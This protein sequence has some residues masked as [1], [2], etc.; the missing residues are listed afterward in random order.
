MSAVFRVDRLHT[1]ITTGDKPALML[2]GQA[3]LAFKQK[4]LYGSY[5]FIYF[6]QIFFRPLPFFFSSAKT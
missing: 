5:F 3:G 2:T 6:K 4:P 1:W